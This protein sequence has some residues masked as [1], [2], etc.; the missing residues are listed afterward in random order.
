MKGFGFTGVPEE[1]RLFE[2]D[3]DA[4]RRWENAD[5]P[6]VVTYSHLAEVRGDDLAADVTMDFP[7]HW[8]HWD[9]GWRYLFNIS[10][11][12]QIMACRPGDLILDYA[13]GPCWVAELLN[14]FGIRT[15]SVDLSLEMLRRGRERLRQDRRLNRVVNA[16][17]AAGDALQLPFPDGTFDGVLCMNALHHMPNYL[18]ALKEIHRVLK[19]GGRAAF[20][21]PGSAHARYP[22]TQARM[23]EIGVLEKST[24][25]PLLFVL[26]RRAGFDRMRVVPLVH[27][28]RYEFEYSAGPADEEALRRM[29]DLASESIREHSCFIL[30]KGPTRPVDSAMPAAV[31][32]SHLLRADIKVLQS[33]TYAPAGGL[34]RDR[35]SVRNVGDVLWLARK[36]PFGGNV[37]AGVKVY[38]EEGALIRED[39]CRTF[40]PQDTPP[41]G[42][43][44]LEM[45]VPAMFHPGRYILKYDMVIENLAWFEHHGSQATQHSVEV[46]PLS[47]EMILSETPSRVI[48]GDVITCLARLRNTGAIT[49]PSRQESFGGPMSVGI[50]VMREDG[51]FLRDDLGRTVLPRDVPPSSDIQIELHIPVQLDPGRYL[52]KFDMV[53]EGSSWLESTGSPVIMRPVDVMSR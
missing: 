12:G 31:L 19:E 11:L 42:E 36:S 26:A 47:A 43:V 46:V 51:A 2:L 49:W 8:R 33:T 44:L 10:L 23:K 41:G 4:L 9:I 14:R 53:I 22:L 18:E 27:P 45:P 13:A 30:E 7:L 40:L 6:E 24:P 20:S 50:R 32:Y 25:L 5:V 48:S 16:Q 52:F 28:F 34:I 37:M 29:W 35:I 38:S 17:F 3:E 21:E 15:V 39:L 1:D